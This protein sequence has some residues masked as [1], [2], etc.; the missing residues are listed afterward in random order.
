MICWCVRE[1]VTVSLT[2][3]YKSET[4]LCTPQNITR[5]R[6]AG[7]WIIYL[8]VCFNQ[9]S[10]IHR[11][12]MHSGWVK[13]M[14]VCRRD[15]NSNFKAS[16]DLDFQSQEPDTQVLRPFLLPLSHLIFISVHL[17]MSASFFHHSWLPLITLIS[18]K[19]QH[20]CSSHNAS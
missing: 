4:K 5:T 13:I 12:E 1:L 19:A 17:S 15:M 10:G 11:I 6:Q 16:K 18:H 14:K 3:D 20:G 7:G 8:L 9:V 2:C